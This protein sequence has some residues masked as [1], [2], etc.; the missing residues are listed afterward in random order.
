MDALELEAVAQAPMAL[1]FARQLFGQR[2]GLDGVVLVLEVDPEETALLAGG[3][4]RLGQSLWQSLYLQFLPQ[5]HGLPPLK[6]GCAY[7]PRT[8][9]QDMAVE[10]NR[11]LRLAL[12]RAMVGGPG[13]EEIPWFELYKDILLGGRLG[14]RF[15]PIVGF[16]DGRALG[17]EALSAGPEDTPLASMSSLLDIAEQTGSLADLDR[18]CHDLAF[19]RRRGALACQ[20]G[21]STRARCWA[22]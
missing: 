21:D 6:T 11:A 18:V 19:S 1:P 10:V 13:L 3:L 15:Q 7:L 14:T 8:T 9:S 5:A 4:W 22:T 12:R 2:L 20:W 17:W 16:A